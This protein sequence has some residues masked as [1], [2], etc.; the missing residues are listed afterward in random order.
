M[1][2]EINVINNLFIIKI[3][4]GKMI[5]GLSNQFTANYTIESK[6]AISILFF[7]KLSWN[8]VNITP[9]SLRIR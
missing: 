1:A 7:L 3:K 9:Y 8:L 5:A 6:L 2:E 4:V